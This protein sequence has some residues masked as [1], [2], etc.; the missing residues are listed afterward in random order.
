LTLYSNELT[1]TIPTEFG[2]LTK[3]KDL[4]LNSNEMIGPV[5]SEIGLLTALTR[6]KLQNNDFTGV[7]PTEICELVK[8]RALA[9]VEVGCARLSCSKECCSC[10]GST[11]AC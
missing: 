11:T 6:M 7:M 4:W 1:S 8:S 3:L 9:P 5:P 2:R 10:C